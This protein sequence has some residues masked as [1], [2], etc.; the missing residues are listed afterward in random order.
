[1]TTTPQ[2]PRDPAERASPAVALATAIGILRTHAVLIAVIMLAAVAGSLAWIVTHDPRYE[3]RA[4]ILVSPV[5]ENDQTYLEIPVLRSSG[6]DPARAVHT[7]AGLLNTGEARRRAAEALATS[8]SEISAAL[9]VEP[10][11]DGNIVVVTATSPNPRRAAEI[12]NAYAAAA[13]EVRGEE[14]QPLVAASIRRIEGELASITDTSSL[15]AQNLRARLSSL[16]TV[17]DG[18]DPTLSVSERASAPSSPS[19]PPRW[20]TLAVAAFGGF[21]LG[22]LAALLTELLV[23]R[24]ATQESDLTEVISAPVLARVPGDRRFSLTADGA[25]AP[26][27]REAFRSLRGRLVFG[28][29]AVDDGGGGKAAAPAR[30]RTVLMTSASRGDGRTTAALNLADVVI[31]GGQSA[32]VLEFDLRAPAIAN[33]LGV[34]SR[35]TLKLLLEPGARLSHG[36]VSV[37]GKEGFELGLAPVQSDLQLFEALLP[38]MPR[39][40]AAAA[41]RA[42][43]VIIDAPALGQVVDA[44]P[45]LSQVD[46]IIIVGRM[47][48]TTQPALAH[49]GD[50]LERAHAVPTGFLAVGGDLS[51]AVAYYGYPTDEPAGRRRRRTAD[52][53]AA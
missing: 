12:A 18:Q 36:L 33:R 39:V 34:E 46:D 25:P 30:G 21:A 14:L 5:A 7:A 1:M 43:W 37:P 6:P 8:D 13:L 48:H 19:G 11:E 27:V 40:I 32:I 23:A 31:A 4:E 16:R 38:W 9:L 44:L 42:D 28:E 50:L 51:Q 29:G 3:A 22:A 53:S 10:D 47:G 15:A 24:R 35:A 17:Q 20:V 49:L 45:L 2:R 41:A 26:A 52:P